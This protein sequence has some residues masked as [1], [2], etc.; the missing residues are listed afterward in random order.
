[1]LQIAINKKIYR[2]GL[3]ASLAFIAM[4]ASFWNGITSGNDMFQHYQFAVTVRDSIAA[5]VVYPSFA[6]S[7]NHGFGDVAL[8]FY[9]P[10]SY[11]ILDGFYFLFNDWFVASLVAFF[12]VFFVGGV[13]VYL[14]ARQEFSHAQ[15]LLAAGI[16]IFAPYHLNQIYNNFLFAEFSASAVIPFCFLFVTR[17]CRRGHWLDILGLAASYA[18]LILTHLPS[19]VIG[20]L[21]LLFY[22]LFLLRREN[23]LPTLARLFSSVLLGLGLSSFYW[24]RMAMELGWVKHSSGPY[25]SGVWGYSDNFLFTLE[26][27]N[28][29]DSVENLWL[30]DLML[31][32]MLVIAVPSIAFLIRRSSRPSQFVLAAGAGF[33]FSAFMAVIISK[34]VWDNLKFIQDVQFPWRWLGLVSVFGALF[35]S[36]GLVHYSQALSSGGKTFLPIGIGASMLLFV[37]VS[38]FVVKGAVYL[39]RGE[40]NASINNSEGNE[41]FDGWWPVWA[42]RS[43]FSQTERVSAQDRSV[44]VDT[45]S[46]TEKQFAIGSGGETVARVATLYYPHWTA[47]VNGTPTAVSPTENGLISL[48]VPA[49]TVQVT[50]RFE[51]PAVVKAAFWVSGVLW[52]LTLILGAFALISSLQQRKRFYTYG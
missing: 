1:M 16:F 44:A 51:E 18:L 19:A 14:W 11:Y 5:G 36:L 12:S 52:F 34:P 31:L 7:M 3:I 39:P 28:F 32:A 37:F 33:L 38:A 10:L 9:P 49:E 27:L 41:T 47:E 4:S 29:Q 48:H 30:A 17:V 26:S 43:A 13:G 15:S 25:L 6:G 24:L 20:S 46:A 45:W 21:A 2:I 22:T 35:A 50:L 23:T 42:D 40:F 8:R